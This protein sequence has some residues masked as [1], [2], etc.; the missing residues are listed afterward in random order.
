M[1]GIFN[2][3]SADVAYPSY[4]N[5]V[6]QY[7]DV[8]SHAVNAKISEVEKPMIL[9]N[10]FVSIKSPPNQRYEVITSMWMFVTAYSSTP[11]QTDETPL[12]TASGSHVRDGVIATNFLPIGTK[13]RLPTIYGD[14]IFVVEDRM[15]ERYYYRADVWMRTREEAKQFG[16][17][18]APIEVLHEY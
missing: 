7:D 4:D 16:L 17:K 8:F 13:I 10:S 2:D 9:N 12:I 6:Q 3:A 11:D 15:N 18:N 5:G 14:K 1:L